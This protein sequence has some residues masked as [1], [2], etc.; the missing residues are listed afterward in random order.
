MSLKFS[1]AAS[2]LC[3]N[4]LC[5]MAGC[6][7]PADAPSAKPPPRGAA[8]DDKAALRGGAGKVDLGLAIADPDRRSAA[9]AASV[10]ASVPP[11]TSL[12]D[13]RARL[14]AE[15]FR[16]TD[17]PPVEARTPYRVMECTLQDMVQS[18]GHIWTVT[19]DTGD[20]ATTAGQRSDFQVL[21]LGAS[22]PPPKPPG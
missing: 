19:F 6:A 20:G 14:T 15:T 4:A 5:L 2:L 8:P 12:A 9:F 16:C 18:C 3:L 17:L 22:P 7:A 13:A 11:G 21:C 1:A 10:A